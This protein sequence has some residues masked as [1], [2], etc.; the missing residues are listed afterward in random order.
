[1]NTVHSSD[2]KEIILEEH[3]QHSQKPEKKQNGLRRIKRDYEK[4]IAQECKEN[5]KA[6]YKYANCKKKTRLPIS[7]LVRPSGTSTT[8]DR[9]VSDEL[10]KQFESVFTDEDEREVLIFNDFARV[11]DEN[12]QGS[13]DYPLS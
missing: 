1:M 6:F 8:S 7:Q 10:S 3:T 5:P 4:R 13:F 12:K 9:K 2:T 11:F